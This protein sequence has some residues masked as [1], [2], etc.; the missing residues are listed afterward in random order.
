MKHQLIIRN[1][2][3]ASC[4]AKI[5]SILKNVSGVH[6]ASLNY[7]SKTATV[8]GDVKAQT[9]ID[10]L[11][12]EGYEAKP[13]D[14]QGSDSA[15]EDSSHHYHRMLRKSVFA[16][17]VGI[18]LFID[19]F[20][21]WLPRVDVPYIQW[22]WVIVAVFG[23]FVLYF[24]GGHIFKSAWKSFWCHSANMDTL[25]ALGTGIAWLYSTIVVLIPFWIP[26]IARHVYFDTSAILI[27]FITFGAALEVRARGKTSEAIKRLIGLQPKT[28]RVIRDGE[29]ID[30]PIEEIQAGDRLR[31]RPGEKIAVDGEILEGDSQID[32]SMLTGEPL[33]VHKK[34][35][36]EVVGGTINKSGTFIYKATH[37]GKDTALAHIVEM[38]QQAQN[39]KPTIGRLADKVSSLFV[40]TVVIIAILT[41][42]GWYDFGP[43]P[44]A[45]FVLV[46]SVAVLVIACP[47]ALGLAT[48]I[49]VIVGVG[50]AAEIGILIRNGDA[51]QTATKLT[52]I[53]LDKTGTVTEGKPAL[54]HVET[55][56][57]VDETTLLTVA[58]SVEAGS[59]HPLAEAIVVGAKKK[60]IKPKN[61]T[62]FQAIT[63]H[64]VT[65]LYENQKAYLGKKQLMDQNNIDL[66][67]LPEIAEK[68][69]GEGQ[70]PMYVALN[71][72]ALGIVSVADPIKA[73]SKDA[74]AQLQ[75]K[76]LKVVMITGDNPQ[77]AK[78]VAS[79]VGIDDFI[80]EV[81][82]QDKAEKVSALQQKGEIVGMVGDGINDAPALASADVGF[83]IG[84]G[85]DVA[86][87]SADVTLMGGSLKGV[88]N[89][90]AIS[91]ATVSNIKQNLFGAFVYNT[92]GIPIAAGVFYPLV[93][94]LLNPVIA[95]AAMALS[96]VT[97]VTN[98]NRLRFFH[99]YE[100]FV[101]S[102]LNKLP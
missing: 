64:G 99:K 53:V 68:L 6:T 77:T 12:K 41:A 57:G 98:A 19:L 51:L 69:A 74:I 91:R 95:G 24:S 9:L 28:A 38:V 81:L 62:G 100:R 45:A 3:C 46:T 70:T 29:E 32:E 83:A 59:E 92:L 47:C 58:A 61:V 22:P 18:P 82:P 13:V 52:T 60:N 5:E 65:A 11:K 36:D 93:G 44:K 31:V 42:L 17:I 90:I 2:H 7:A 73:D 78:A 96:S 80:A 10:T 21:H 34:Q 85:T 97:V 79:A 50:K 23:F 67:N 54:V 63:G 20:W 101:S 102:Q 87:E 33:P 26:T 16:I 71:G 86:I 15:T 84:T 94:V 27:A 75:K 40:P 37:V 4:V 89:S 8:E 76:G 39:S 14:D 1:I 43:D 25:V 66:K 48:P 55:L 72:K 49:S 30:V 35:G 88:V 56:E